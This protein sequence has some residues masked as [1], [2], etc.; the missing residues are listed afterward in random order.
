MACNTILKICLSCKESFSIIQSQNE[1]AEQNDK[2]KEKNNKQTENFAIETVKELM[3]IIKYLKHSSKLLIYESIGHLIS[4][5]KDPIEINKRLIEV[6]SD[7]LNKFNEIIK[8]A[9]LNQKN[10][11]V[12]IFPLILLCSFFF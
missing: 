12:F 6:M 4:G 5:L 9:H 3:N 11:K 2:E 10:L 1:V 7:Y 8:Q